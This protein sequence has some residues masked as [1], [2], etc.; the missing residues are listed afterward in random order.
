MTGQG[1][2]IESTL[3]LGDVKEWV[4]KCTNIEHLRSLYWETQNRL[5]ILSVHESIATKGKRVL[6][7]LENGTKVKGT[8][9]KYSTST[10]MFYV[11][12]DY[13]ER[14]ALP[15]NRVEWEDDNAT[16]KR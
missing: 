16:N 8:I 3:T 14:Y 12:S 5:T 11:I 6:V 13:G 1:K 10:R 15:K 9:E 4:R 2:R 7:R